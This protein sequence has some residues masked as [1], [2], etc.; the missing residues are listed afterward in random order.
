M[1]EHDDG[2]WVDWDDVL[3]I[4]SEVEWALMHLKT[5]IDINGINMGESDAAD[6]LRRALSPN[7]DVS[8]SGVNN[9]KP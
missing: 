7:A 2:E 1:D 5:N 8:A 9:Q 4:L 6:A 3:R